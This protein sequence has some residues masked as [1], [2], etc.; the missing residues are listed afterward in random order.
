MDTKIQ[1]QE[2]IFCHVHWL[3]LLG[4]HMWTMTKIAKGFELQVTIGLGPILWNR[5]Q[6]QLIN[7]RLFSLHLL[8]QC[9]SFACSVITAAQMGTQQD[10]TVA[11]QSSQNFPTQTNLSSS[12]GTSTS[13]LLSFLHVLW[14]KCAPSSGTDFFFF[15]KFWKAT[16]NNGNFLSQWVNSSCHH[17]F[18][19]SLAIHW[20]ILNFSYFHSF[21]SFMETF[22]P[23]KASYFFDIFCLFASFHYWCCLF[24]LVIE[25]NWGCFISLMRNVRLSFSSLIWLWYRFYFQVWPCTKQEWTAMW[26]YFSISKLYIVQIHPFFI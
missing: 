23:K 22:H 14:L 19:G 15:T 16:T 25:F 17:C 8:H 4:S 12:G 5:I 24:V 20:S 7:G 11:D 3:W 18:Q 2:S 21:L 9:V 10:N 26:K 13:A 1:T 6:I